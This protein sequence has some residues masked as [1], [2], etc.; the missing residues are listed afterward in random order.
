MVKYSADVGVPTYQN[1]FK[2]FHD[3]YFCR[4]QKEHN[5]LIYCIYLFFQLMP[6]LKSFCIYCSI[7]IFFLFLMQSTLFPAC[8]TLNQRRI[9]ARR[10][11]LFP[12]I[13]YTEDYTPNELSQKSIVHA[14]FKKYFAPVLLSIP[15]KVGFWHFLC[16][17]LFA[18]N[19]LLDL[20]VFISCRS[21]CRILSLCRSKNKD[22]TCYTTGS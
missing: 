6:V 9:E 15:G 3:S 19:N 2:L 7:G 14:G 13:Q 17:F 8:L 12:C 18:F 22:L 5:Y 16:V 21:N 20:L 11:G 10:D 1:H 4:T